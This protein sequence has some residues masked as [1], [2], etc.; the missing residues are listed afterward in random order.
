MPIL[1]TC[2]CNCPYSYR[3]SLHSNLSNWQI[4]I[5]SNFFCPL[6]QN[7]LWKVHIFKWL[8]IRTNR[9]ETWIRWVP[10]LNVIPEILFMEHLPA[11]ALELL[12]SFCCPTQSKMGKREMSLVS[13]PGNI[14][15]GSM[16]SFYKAAVKDFRSWWLSQKVVSSPIFKL[17]FSCTNIQY[18][19]GVPHLHC[20]QNLKR[21]L[22]RSSPSWDLPLLQHQR[23]YS[24]LWI[25]TKSRVII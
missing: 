2:D 8:S 1:G 23:P 3:L 10:I 7:V 21:E 22:I 14:G 11:I 13:F 15:L 17:R 24:L 4:P 6:G 12:M 19:N 18:I 20:L 5:Y 25:T 9:F 16:E